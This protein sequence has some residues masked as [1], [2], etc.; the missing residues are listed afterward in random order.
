MAEDASLLESSSAEAL[1]SMRES[2]PFVASPTRRAGLQRIRKPNPRI[3][4]GDLVEIPATP[5]ARKVQKL[6]PTTPRSTGKDR[7][8]LKEL[9]TRLRNLLK[10]PKAH[11]WVCY[12]WFYSNID[13]ALFEGENDFCI[14]LRE[15]FPQLRTTTLSRQQWRIIRRL[16]GKPRRCSAAFFTEERQALAQKRQRIRVLQQTRSLDCSDHLHDLPEQV[17][18][19]L[20]IGTKVTARL[21]RPQNGL[22][23]GVIDAV[24]TCNNA[25][26]VTFDRP[27]LGTHTVHDI[28]VLSVDSYETFPLSSF[29]KRPPIRL[30]L[31]TPP[32]HHPSPG[33]ENDPLLGS[34]PTRVSSLHHHTLGGF[35]VK[36]LTYITKVTKLL[37][38]KKTMLSEL[39]E[40]NTE[41]ERMRSQDTEY[42]S[43]FQQKYAMHLLD[44]DQLNKKVNENF[45]GVLQSWK[46]VNPDQGITAIMQTEEIKKKC[47]TEATTIV[48]KTN[49]TQE[50]GERLKNSK[51]LT[52]IANLLSL[53]LQIRTFADSEL[54]SFEFK[55]LQESLENIKCQLDPSNIPI[56]QNSIQLHINHIEHGLSQSGNLQSFSESALLDKPTL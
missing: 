42:P 15:S 20:V 19:A 56:F 32:R 2:R 10:L 1:L 33:L 12:E 53:M 55:S 45:K 21:R 31:I 14:C 13:K 35:P 22:Y 23:M 41:A 4:G 9:G 8:L 51:N 37:G 54:H 27:G 36:F 49:V 48:H 39:K 16:M 29:I 30:P 38:I 28:D 11:L 46:E 44:F 5:K 52:L 50:G 3:F 34:S 18:M 25:Y 40:L 24:D 43:S 7:R 17:P 47:L 6:D 26:R